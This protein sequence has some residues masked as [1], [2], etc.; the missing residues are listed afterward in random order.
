DLANHAGSYAPANG[1]RAGWVNT[2]DL[3]ISQE[4]PSFFD[5]HRAEVWF[6]IQNV[7]N[8][9]NDD[10]GHIIDYGFFANARV[11]SL[12]GIYNGQYVYNY[13][14]ADEPSPANNDADNFNQGV[15]Q[16]SA[17]VGFRYRF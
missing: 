17:Q 13:R 2:F 7:G 4:I 8:L 1:F 15:S 10:W 9:I 14:F 5:G 3:K 16:W 11:A 6:E 12:Q